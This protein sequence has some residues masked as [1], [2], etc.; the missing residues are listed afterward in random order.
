MPKPSLLMLEQVNNSNR[1]H[2]STIIIPQGPRI[3]EAVSLQVE[4]LVRQCFSNTKTPYYPK[5][6]TNKLPA[7]STRA[8]DTKSLR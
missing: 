8:R 7:S 6:Q 4:E 3:S 2:R 5:H 1:A